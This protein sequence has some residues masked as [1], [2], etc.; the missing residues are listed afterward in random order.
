MVSTCWSSPNAEEYEKIYSKGKY[1]MK[2]VEIKENGKKNE[3]PLC[4]HNKL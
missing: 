4:L 3:K 2:S 1:K